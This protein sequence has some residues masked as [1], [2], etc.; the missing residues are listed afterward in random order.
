MC[1]LGVAVGWRAERF[2]DTAVCYPTPQQ[3]AA[4]YANTQALGGDDHLTTAGNVNI[5]LLVRA[6]SGDNQ[7]QLAGGPAVVVG[8]VGDDA[9]RSLANAPSAM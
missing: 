2:P 5:P 3:T 1:R 6:G 8:G 4:V 9:C 7:I